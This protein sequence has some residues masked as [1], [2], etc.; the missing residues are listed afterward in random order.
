MQSIVH[1]I[2]TMHTPTNGYALRDG[3][4]PE[5]SLFGN[6]TPNGESILVQLYEN[7]SQGWR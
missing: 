6:C 4:E 5:L 1:K 7:H 2:H 3:S